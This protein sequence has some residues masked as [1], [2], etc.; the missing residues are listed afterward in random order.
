M[1]AAA[2]VGVVA[3][4]IQIVEKIAVLKDPETVLVCDVN[5][6]LSCTN[7]LDAWQ[8]SVLGPPNAFIGAVL[9]SIFAGVGLTSVL[10]TRQS[11][12]ALLTLLGVITFFAA[13]AT[14]Y[15]AQTAF[16][17]GALC[18]WCI[19][20]TTAILCIGLCVTRAL[21]ATSADSSFVR[22]ITA[23]GRD[24][25]IWAGWWVVIA[26]VIIVGLLF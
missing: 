6:V 15:M 14:W 16:V 4:G 2:L 19:F 25:V 3:T 26:A 24:Y 8:S 23:G 9:F 21:K 20:I 18:L 12:P 11:R 1:L 10:G 22:A 17:I 7:V 13:F 5:S